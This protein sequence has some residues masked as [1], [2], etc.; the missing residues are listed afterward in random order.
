MS[1]RIKFQMV[2][3]ASFFLAGLTFAASRALIVTGLIG[4][5][6]NAD[7]L[8]RLAMETKRLLAERGVPADGINV[9]DGKVTREG[10]LA[11]MQKANS[12]KAGDEFWLVFYGYAGKSQ[13]GVPAFQVSGPRLTADDMK[14]ALDAIPARQFV[15]IGTNESGAFLPVLQNARRAIVSATKD[16]DESDQPRF[17]T[18]WVSALT[19]NPKASF[20]WIAA[21]ASAMVDQ[22]YANSGLAQAEHARLADPVTG[23]ILEPPFGV[24]LAAPLENLSTEPDGQAAL[25]SA[26]DIK[27]AVQDPNA[28]WALRVGSTE[29]AS[30]GVHAGDRGPGIGGDL[31]KDRCEN[32]RARCASRVKKANCR[33]R[34]LCFPAPGIAPVERSGECQTLLGPVHTNGELRR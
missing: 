12:L 33:R 2:I 18:E 16:D 17:P 23:Q 24:N 11:A 4:S 26:S 5:A 25:P 31:A 19:E 29:R 1:S 9:M 27:V 6:E 15:L 32:N 13:G 30:A 34:R 21:R 3:L 28:E 22:D 8:R 20:A 14:G 10:V 7:E